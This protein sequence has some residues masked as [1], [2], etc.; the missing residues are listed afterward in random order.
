MNQVVSPHQSD[1]P[2]EEIRRRIA[3]YRR[4]G[5]EHH[6]P[7]IMVYPEEQHACPWPDCNC[8]IVG[9]RFNLE[10]MGDKQ[11]TEDLLASFWQGPGLIGRCPGC[12]RHVLFGYE[13]KQRVSDPAQ[14]A[15][16][17]LPDDWATKAHIRPRSTS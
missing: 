1:V 14:F 12:G 16:A 8:S 9:I 2:P 5:Y 7:A 13:V 11:R 17:L 15:S 10:S 6:S 3:E 4:L